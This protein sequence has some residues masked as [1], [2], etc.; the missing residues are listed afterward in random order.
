MKHLDIGQTDI[1]E[2]EYNEQGLIVGSTFHN[3]H[4]GQITKEMTI[5]ISVEI[6]SVFSR[7][8]S[9]ANDCA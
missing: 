5:P 4:L 7:R 1:E 6:D 9:H 2:F 3:E 8:V